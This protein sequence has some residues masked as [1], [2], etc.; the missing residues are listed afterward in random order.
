[1]NNNYYVYQYVDEN[2][3][4]YYIGKGKEKRID[5]VHK[6]TVLPPKHRRIKIAENLTNDEAKKLEV[7]LINTFER[8]IDG[9]ILD[10]IKIN[11]WACRAGWTHSN[12]AKELISQK[13]LGKVRSQESIEKYRLAKSGMTDETKE[14]IRKAN[15]G[16]KDDGRYLKASTTLKGKPWSEARRNAFLSKKASGEI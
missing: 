7:E 11:Q 8:K 15:L 12:K 5:V 9:G 13:N 16:R 4:P 3:N 1:M 2:G 6:H 14:K 10:N